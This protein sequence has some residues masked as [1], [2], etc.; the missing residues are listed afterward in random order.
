MSASLSLRTTNRWPDGLRSTQWG[1]GQLTEKA[2]FELQFLVELT[3]LEVADVEELFV[4]VEES[5]VVLGEKA[6]HLLVV[7]VLFPS[8][9]AVLVE[10]DELPPLEVDEDFVGTPEED[11]LDLPGELTSRSGG[12][13]QWSGSGRR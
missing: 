7:K 9:E 4:G 13:R 12:W 5:Q 10:V 6:D 2:P 1:A 3:G 8:E 11:P